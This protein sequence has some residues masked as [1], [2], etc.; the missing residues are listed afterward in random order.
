MT[1]DGQ[2]A[3]GRPGAWLMNEPRDRIYH[4][5]G[6]PFEIGCALGQSLGPKLEANIERYLRERTCHEAPFDA[7]LWQAGAL[8]WLRSLP[9]RFREEFEGLAQGAQ[10]PLQRLAE[11]AYLEVIL[12]GRCSGAILTI[13]HQAWVARNNDTFAPGMWGY[14]T[15]REVSGRIPAMSFGLEGDVFTPTGI[16]RERLW[17]HYNYLPAWDAPTPGRAHLPAYALMVE[18]LETCQTLQ[19][20][21]ALLERIQRD[22]GMLLFAIDGKTEAYGLYECSCTDFYKRQTAKGWLV[23]T[24]HYC[25]HPKAPPPNSSGPLSTTSRY[26]RMEALVESLIS[27]G[28]QASPVKELIGILADDGIEARSGETVT[29]YSNVACPSAGEIWYTFGGYP[30]ASHGNWQKLE[31]PW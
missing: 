31:W 15:I 25:A 6:S 7:E 11:W 3:L 9:A 23:G 26:E 27:Q 8:P 24:N 30:A 4:L 20:T 21:E 10:L 28:G 18:A 1:N 12:S 14:V 2:A 16:N 19:E 5:K 13:G 29:A 17:L 22:D